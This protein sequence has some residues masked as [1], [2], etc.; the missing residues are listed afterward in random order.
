MG[1]DSSV[2]TVNRYGLDGPEIESRS[3][4]DFPHPS[5]QAVEPTQ[6]PIQWVPVLFPGGCGVDHPPPPGAEVEERVELYMYYPSGPSWP[7]LG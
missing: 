3:S 4:R 6:L 7:V 1:R 5:R 2:G